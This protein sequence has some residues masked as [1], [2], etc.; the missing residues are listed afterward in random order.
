MTIT[1]ID[2]RAAFTLVKQN[3]EKFKQL[4][5]E[6][7]CKQAVQD[8]ILNSPRLDTPKRVSRNVLEFIPSPFDMDESLTSNGFLSPKTL[9]N[10]LGSTCNCSRDSKGWSLEEQVPPL[11]LTSAV[12]APVPRSN[13]TLNNAVDSFSNLSA[14]VHRDL[15]DPDA[16]LQ[17]LHRFETEMK[18]HIR[19]IGMNASLHLDDLQE[20]I[21]KQRWQD[22]SRSSHHHPAKSFNSSLHRLSE[23]L[24]VDPEEQRKLMEEIE[25]SAALVEGEDS[26]DE[27]GT[28]Y[29][30]QHH[31]EEQTY[32]QQMDQLQVDAQPLPGMI[33]VAPGLVLPL[34]SAHD[35]LQEVLEGRVVVTECSCCHQELTCSED[36]EYLLCEDCMVCS[37]IDERVIRQRVGA[38]SRR[39]VCVGHRTKDLLRVLSQAR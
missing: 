8:V 24:G 3:S 36:A 18:L 1:V 30:E 16:Q 35:Q 32:I 2:D 28:D 13:G 29:A 25:K 9:D 4:L 5:A 20:D 23:E 19:D 15:Q 34:I 22:L 39:G 37:P 21:Q 10:S 33:A 38:F 6:C 17:Q 26:D 14:S 27:F 7:D 12:S 31:Q 11:P